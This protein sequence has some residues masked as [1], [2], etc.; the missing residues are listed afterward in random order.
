MG[1]N[2]Y[3]RFVNRSW[4]KL[5]FPF[6]WTYHG[7]TLLRNKAFDWGVFKSE[8]YQI[9]I[10]CVGNLSVGGTGKTPMIEW[11]I[12]QLSDSMNVAILSR[13]YKR[14]S[15]GFQLYN[16]KSTAAQMGDEP[17]Q[18]AQK[19]KNITVAVDADRRNGIRQ[20]LQLQPKLQV[21]LLDDAFQHRWVS[22]DLKIVL[23]TFDQPY[24]S[25]SVLPSGN[26][27]E[28]KS[29]AS[30][31]DII[32][33]TKCP[34]DLSKTDQENIKNQLKLQAHQSCFF[35]TI[36]YSTHL[37]G[38]GNPLVSD[39]IKTEFVLVTG[40]A[41]PSALLHYLDTHRANYKHLSFSDHHR[42]STLDIKQIKV[43]AGKKPILTTEKDAVRLQSLL[44]QESLFVLPIK[45]QF[46][47]DSTS[48][49]TAVKRQ[50][51]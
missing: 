14:N 35:S 27:R 5:L 47:N 21:I 51:V 48:L 18:I 13:G 15:S 49:M 50:F 24:Y 11:L 38:I 28:S 22:S 39:F 43:T 12:H 8:S 40:I 6:T 36:G 46:L 19:F 34:K 30:R 44:P 45:I 32:V 42:F 7:V 20:L 3:F 9:P 26:L 23:T 31:A 16:S 37:K 29:G 17:F 10:I 1:L 4:R 33:V 2:V 25:D 41:Q